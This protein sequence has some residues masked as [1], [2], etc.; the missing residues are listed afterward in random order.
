MIEL[1]PILSGDEKQQIKQLRDYLVRL[2]L[3]LDE[4]EKHD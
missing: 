2:V 4:E 1:P 3:Q